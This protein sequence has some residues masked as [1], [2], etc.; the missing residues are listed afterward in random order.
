MPHSHWESFIGEIRLPTLYMCWKSISWMLCPHKHKVQLLYWKPVQ[1]LSHIQKVIFPEAGEVPPNPVR[2]DQRRPTLSES[3]I[4]GYWKGPVF[5]RRLLWMR[6]RQIVHKKKKKINELSQECRWGW[7]TNPSKMNR[8]RTFQIHHAANIGR[9]LKWPILLSD[10]CKQTFKEER[11]PDSWI[12][13]KASI[14][15]QSEKH[16]WPTSSASLLH[17]QLILD[18]FKPPS[19][20]VLPNLFFF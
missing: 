20:P 4:G 16:R 13:S 8:L 3:G 14:A 2:L 9:V 7:R 17:K 11:G 5:S 12:Q 19:K 6:R 10:H 18:P 15:S 1:H